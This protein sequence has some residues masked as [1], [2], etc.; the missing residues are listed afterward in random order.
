MRVDWHHSPRPAAREG[1]PPGSRLPSHHAHEHDIVVNPVVLG[2]LRFGI[3]LLGHG[4][5]RDAL[6][7]WFD[8]VIRRIRCVPIDANTGL[9]WTMLP[10]DLRSRGRSI[11]VKDS[12]IAASALARGLVVATRHRGDFEQA[13]V[14]VVDPSSG[15]STCQRSLFGASDRPG[16]R[17]PS[18]RPSL[19]CGDTDAES[20]SRER[21]LA[22]AATGTRY[23]VD[24]PGLPGAGRW[25]TACWVAGHPPDTLHKGRKPPESKTLAHLRRAARRRRGL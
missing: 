15:N 2:E 12:L 22:A 18:P 13:G 8:E 17:L 16:A 7:V 1:S 11:P 19:L 10:A 21:L 6:E 3:R 20:F 24:C 4:R 5:R 25:A 9:R 23:H 14:E